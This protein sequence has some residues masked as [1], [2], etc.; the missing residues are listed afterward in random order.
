[1]VNIAALLKQEI[2]RIVRKE[3]KSETESLKKTNSRY[4]SEIAEMKRRVTSLEQQ[5]KAVGRK[6]PKQAPQAASEASAGGHPPASGN[7]SLR[8]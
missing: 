6:N 3:L 4:R 8:K 2:S 7:A 5:L 1:M